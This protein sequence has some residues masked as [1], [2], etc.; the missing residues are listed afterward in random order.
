MALSSS[1]LLGR[2]EVT[3]LHPFAIQDCGE[4]R[5]DVFE[6][7]KWSVDTRENDWEQPRDKVLGAKKVRGHYSFPPAQ[8]LQK[9]TEVGAG[10]GDP[11]LPCAPGSP[12][13]WPCPY[14]CIHR[15]MVMF[16]K[17]LYKSYWG[18]LSLHGSFLCS[19]APLPDHS[20]WGN[21]MNFFVRT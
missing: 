16:Q 15:R 1:L 9:P 14:H 20:G 18:I 10:S 17:L 13:P 12:T 3:V 8:L 4:D 7:V 19:P 11:S 6:T 5:M 2:M 21:R